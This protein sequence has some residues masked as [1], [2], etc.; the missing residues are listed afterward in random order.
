MR[1][2][3]IA[4][5]I[6][7]RT[8]ATVTNSAGTINTTVTATVLIAA[9]F[10]RPHSLRHQL[11]DRVAHHRQ[12]CS[13]RKRH[14]KRRKNQINEIHQQYHD[15]IEE[16][17]AQSFLSGRIGGQR[18]SSSGSRKANS[19]KKSLIEAILGFVN[20]VGRRTHIFKR[21]EVRDVFLRDRAMQKRGLRLLACLSA[22]NALKWKVT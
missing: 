5:P 4:P 8:N 15:A 6:P 7:W 21:E 18:S 16:R 12:H 17:S 2:G 11:E 9:A 22:A 3:P 10:V 1:S 20:S 19:C 14:Q 13:P